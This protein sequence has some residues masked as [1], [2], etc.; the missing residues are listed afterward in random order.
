AE[1]GPLQL[2]P[3]EGPAV[4]R[5]TRPGL[6]FVADSANHTY[7]PRIV[8]LGGGNYDFTEVVSGLKEGEHVALLTALAL[9]SQRQQMN[10]R[11]RQGMGVPGMTQG[12]G[13]G[14]R[15]GR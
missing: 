6:V 7:H 4:S 3:S 14:G 12:G 13:R 11:I 8:L 10:D 5:R 1:G 15:G 9:Q 2:S